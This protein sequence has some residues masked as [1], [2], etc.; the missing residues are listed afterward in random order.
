VS[1]SA[2]S[3]PI[4]QRGILSSCFR[5]ILVRDYNRGQAVQKA[6]S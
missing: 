4:R 5:R 1:S 3:A 6:F 2:E